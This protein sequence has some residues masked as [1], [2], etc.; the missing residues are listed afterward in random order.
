MKNNNYGIRHTEGDGDCFFSVIR[1]AY[2]QIGYN[3]T[4]EKMRALLARELTDETY[5]TYR[6]IYLGF[7]GEFQT[8]EKDMKD[9][10]KLSGE[11]KKQNDKA[12]DK[13]VSKRILEEGKRIV[14]KFNTLKS[15]KEDVAAL[16]SDY[17]F[18]KD[19]DS[20]EKFRG[21][22][23]TRNFWADTWAISVIEKLLN[24]KVI[25]LS[26]RSYN[27][28]ELDNVLQCGQL[29]DSDL[30]NQGR[31]NPDLYIMTTYSGA[32]YELITYKDKRIFKFPEVP[33]NIKTLVVNKC[34][35]RNS[36]P[37]Y[38]IKDFRNFK[39]RLGLSP[40]EGEQNEDDDENMEYELYEQDI[41]FVFHSKSD[42]N[43]KAGKGLNEII[44]VARLTE[45]NGLNMDKDKIC[46]DWRR[47]LDDSWMTQFNLD[48]HKWAS[49]EHFLLGSQYKKGFPDFYQ[50][51]SLDSENEIAKDLSVAI[52][53]G[54]G[55]GKL[56]ERILRPKQVK[57]DPDF[58]NIGPNNPSE[59]ARK[60]AL[61][62]KFTQNMDLKKV[63][64]ET[65]NAKLMK[66]V[67]GSPAESD[68][69]LMKL[70]KELQ[71]SL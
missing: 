2:A 46:K 17:Q 57:A 37:Y 41:I 52:S 22:I 29:T 23:Q 53:A 7:L 31:F 34:L 26:E 36:G 8:R 4:V 21:F 6:T 66:H 58:Y 69:P 54:K 18:M 40:D 60:K 20:L 16:M 32:H 50:L 43:P 64:L 65:K 35:E 49:V 3:I 10:K 55:N 38:L 70:R 25:I 56:K 9:L 44:P 48:G 51:F 67:R 13:E 47:K 63:L 61:Y 45:F 27:A 42:C 24:I 62:A 14:E 1:D 12:K 28:N 71:K 19:I 33:Y 5:Q 39:A 68:V 30:E 11:L 59:E 15:E